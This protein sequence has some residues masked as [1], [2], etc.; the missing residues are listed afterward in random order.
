[1]RK[2]IIGIGTV[3]PTALVFAL[4]LALLAQVTFSSASQA[5]SCPEGLEYRCEIPPFKVLSGIL[6]QADAAKPGAR[7]PLLSSALDEARAFARPADTAFAA[8][9]IVRRYAALGG[10]QR[11]LALIEEIVAQGLTDLRDVYASDAESQ[12]AGLLRLVL[13]AA[14]F[15]DLPAV[16]DRVALFLGAVEAEATPF[17]FSFAVADNLGRVAEVAGQTAGSTLFERALIRAE[18]APLVDDGGHQVRLSLYAHLA[19]NAST[20]GLAAEAQ[21]ALGWAERA[22]ASVAKIEDQSAWL[23]QFRVLLKLSDRE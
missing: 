20:A 9:V 19:Q 18:D 22:I 6:R 5:A 10:G 2:A 15:E 8:Q 3:V 14:D 21:R 17:A 12:Y 23:A 13:L 11:A 4:V 7:G 1:M 16:S